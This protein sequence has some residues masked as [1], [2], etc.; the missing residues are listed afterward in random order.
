MT[1]A[2][3]NDLRIA[4]VVHEHVTAMR[5]ILWHGKPCTRFGDRKVFISAI[6]E[7]LTE[8]HTGWSLDLEEFK[9]WLIRA[10]LL[11]DGLGRPLVVLARADLVA[12]M[13][14]GAV[15]RSETRAGLA[16]YHFVLDRAVDGEAYQG[17][18]DRPTRPI[19]IMRAV[20]S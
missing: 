19:R 1:Q 16:E 3:P 13:D 18:R 7:T 11:T 14:T 10:E 8:Y 9:E 12:A 5:S 2:S 20:R 17:R 15:L 4:A 6:H